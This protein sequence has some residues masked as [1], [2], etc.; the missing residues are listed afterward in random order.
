[1]TSRVSA[2][3]PALVRLARPH[4]WSKNLLLLLPALAHHLTWT[5]GLVANMV[6]AF[7]AF[8]L[9]GSFG[10]I[11]NDLHDAAEDRL[12]PTKRKRPI[13]SGAV[14]PR[15]AAGFAAV[16]LLGAAALALTLPGRFGVVLALYAVG[17]T[18]YTLALKRRLLLDVIV[19]AMIY[20]LRLFAGGAAVNVPLSNWFV[21]FAVFFFL[22]LAL[23]KRVTELRRVGGD[24]ARLPGR[25]YGSADIF[26]LAAFG[27][28]SS[29]AA[30]LVYCLYL[31]NPAVTTLYRLPDFLWA[32]LPLLLY[33]QARLWVFALRGELDHDPVVFALRDRVSFLAVGAFFVIVWLAA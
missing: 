29:T 30:A 5:P 11:L 23:A 10:Y 1:V 28:A 22:S 21:P 27:I 4:Q 18:T 32:G 6:R 20:T 9:L 2:R 15:T 16:L 8:S 7:L 12:H 13:A 19:L 26:G 33:W 25:A 24:G 14:S 3:G 31:G 17:A